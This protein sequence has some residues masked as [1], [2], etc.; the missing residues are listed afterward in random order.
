M[1]VDKDENM[2]DEHKEDNLESPK[3][4]ESVIYKTESEEFL[5]DRLVS[6]NVSIKV[7]QYVICNISSCGQNMIELGKCLCRFNCRLN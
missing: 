5:T 4:D 1:N 2:D 6:I 7:I 3:S